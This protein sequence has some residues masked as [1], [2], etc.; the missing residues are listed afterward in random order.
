MSLAARIKDARTRAGLSQAELARRCGIAAP[1]LH[2]L[3]SGKSKSTRQTT[4]LRL[5]KALGKS[6]EWLAF[7]DGDGDGSPSVVTADST[8]T[9][10]E[11]DFLADFRKLTAV[12]K[13][14]VVRMVRS[15]AI[16]K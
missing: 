5:S 10:F 2:D 9:K 1:S 14:V 8:E 13:K 3:E 15:L 6:P 16:D 11:R 7:G 4:L 12:E